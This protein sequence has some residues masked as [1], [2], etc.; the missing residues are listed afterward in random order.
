M[1]GHL[2]DRH[3]HRWDTFKIFRIKNI[4]Y[5]KDIET[6]ILQ[7]HPTNGNRQLGKVPSKYNLTQP[8][9][10]VLK[11][12]KKEIDFHRKNASVDYDWLAAS[13]D[14]SAPS[15]FTCAKLAHAH[16]Q[17]RSTPSGN[18]LRWA[19]RLGAFPY[20]AGCSS[21]RKRPFLRDRVCAFHASL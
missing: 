21:P 11:R 15:G 18:A 14:K 17:G 20:R 16:S 8:F 5:L 4:N 19:K 10:A 9:K 13:G 1:N 2:K 12:L 6:L 3:R 7:I